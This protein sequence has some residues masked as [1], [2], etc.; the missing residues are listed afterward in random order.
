MSKEEMLAKLN[1]ILVSRKFHALVFAIVVILLGGWDGGAG[2][3]FSKEMAEQIV[4]AF[5]GYA[6]FATLEDI[7]F[8]LG[9]KPEAVG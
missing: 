6:G 8:H 2:Y 1:R 9:R 7:A 3:V 5:A 4:L